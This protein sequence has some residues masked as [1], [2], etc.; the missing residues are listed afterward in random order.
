MEP[1]NQTDSEASNLSNR[2]EKL[3]EIDQKQ[4][5][6]EE[7]YY[8]KGENF[9]LF[10]KFSKLLHEKNIKKCQNQY[11]KLFVF[12]KRFDDDSGARL[13]EKGYDEEFKN[14]EIELKQCSSLLESYRKALEFDIDRLS[15]F[16]QKSYGL[17]L[18]SCKDEYVNK[19]VPDN[20]IKSCFNGC[21]KFLTM[22]KE[23]MN[24]IMD[25]SIK[26]YMSSLE[27]TKKS[28]GI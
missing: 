27:E 11:D 9:D 24:E 26:D 17:C 28:P 13:P 20:L 3:L 22:N 18:E 10:N 16:S 4:K 23:T 5:N 25:Y 21:Y 15:L 1:K 7:F 14:A 8:L 6:I 19:K 12:S 2:F